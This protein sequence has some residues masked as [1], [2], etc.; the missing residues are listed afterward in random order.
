MNYFYVGRLANAPGGI[1]V[2]MTQPVP[3]LAPGDAHSIAEICAYVCNPNG[4]IWHAVE[5]GW[6]VDPTVNGGSLDP[7]LFV[8]YWVAGVWT[9]AFNPPQ[10]QRL[11]SAS[12]PG[13][14]LSRS[15]APRQYGIQRVAGGWAFTYQSEAFAFAPDS[16]W[17]GTFTQSTGVE[18]YGEVASASA[19]PST[20]MGNGWFGAYPQAAAF[21]GIQEIGGGGTHRMVVTHPALYKAGAV[22]QDGFSYGGPG[23]SRNEVVPLATV[24]GSAGMVFVNAGDPVSVDAVGIDPGDYA[25]QDADWYVVAEVGGLYRSRMLDGTWVHGVKPCYTG[26]LS[27]ISP[28]NLHTGALAPGSYTVY[29]GVEIKSSGARFY[30]T[31]QVVVRQAGT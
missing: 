9:G 20:W 6:I 25:G 23:K 19:T 28:T 2:D 26:A 10:I 11:P 14:R 18:A 7:H 1:T 16:L 29:F 21:S 8:A 17:N 13:M 3:Y 4:A 5:L 31:A 15:D 30:D 22:D 12:Y 27:A 24:N